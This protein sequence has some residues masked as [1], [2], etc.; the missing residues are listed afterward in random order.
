[1]LYDFFQEFFED[2]FFSPV[3]S[4]T[5]ITR[6]IECPTCKTRLSE[7][8]NTGKFGCGDCYEAFGAYTKSIL[9]NIHSSDTHKGKVSAEAEE[10]ISAKKKILSLKEELKNAVQKQEFEEAARLRDE[11]KMLE[12]EGK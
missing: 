5:K 6:D 10:K 12:E 8:L 9:N 4:Q 1:M 11:I 2:G 7:T 3:S